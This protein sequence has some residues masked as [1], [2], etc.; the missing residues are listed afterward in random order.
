MNTSA[1][2]QWAEGVIDLI[3]EIL[4]RPRHIVMLAGARYREYLQPALD[5]M[6]IQVAVPMEGL[7]LGE[8]LSWLGAHVEDDA[9]G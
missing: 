1:R 2:R 3:K 5:A 8:Q 4:P 7:R 9:T 6:G